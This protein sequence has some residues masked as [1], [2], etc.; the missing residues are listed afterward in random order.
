MYASGFTYEDDYTV[1]TKYIS[2]KKYVE[3][4]AGHRKDK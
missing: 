3:W 2:I 1:N 4:W